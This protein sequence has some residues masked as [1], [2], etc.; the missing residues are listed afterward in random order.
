LST[1]NRAVIGGL[2]VALVLTGALAA[3]LWVS[4]SDL[5]VGYGVLNSK[6]VTLKERYGELSSKYSA[7]LTKYGELRSN[8]TA[9]KERYSSITAKYANLEAKYGNLTLKYGE[10]KAALD[11]LLKKHASLLSNYTALKEA[12]ANLKAKYSRLNTTY[13]NLLRSHASLENAYAALRTNYSEL[14]TSYLS[15]KAGYGTLKT[16]YGE[17][18]ARLDTLKRTYAALLSNYSNLK[19]EYLSLRNEYGA[20]QNKYSN[21]SNEYVTLKAR[22][23]NL[24]NAVKELMNVTQE[25]AGLIDS[26]KPN[27]IDWRSP[28]V[29]SAV[30]SVNF[31]AYPDPYEAI[32][33]WIIKHIYYNSDTPEVVVTSTNATY[34]WVADYY[35]YA[36]ETL[37]NGYGDCEDQA[38]LAAAM[39]EEYWSMEYGKTY[40]LWVVEAVVTYEGV[41]YGHDFLIIPYQGGEAAIIDPTLGIYVPPTNTLAALQE[42]EELSGV[43]ITYVYG[44]FN[45]HEYAYVGTNTLNSLASWINNH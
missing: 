35:Q 27:F 19:D 1:T 6:Y 24:L 37:R 9:L 16:K 12:Y 10:L 18:E 44:A 20:L 21:L 42:Y 38:I 45:P 17:L 30:E 11:T 34:E 14:L 2:T 13:A 31:S 23:G 3:F 43:H 8:E 41:R 22:Y 39:V 40:L 25:R 29:R 15:L 4:L 7:L 36:S 32:M 28:L 33:D 26:F 5:R